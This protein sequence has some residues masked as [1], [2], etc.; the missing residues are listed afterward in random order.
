ML[1]LS[2]S[3]NLRSRSSPKRSTCCALRA[4]GHKSR[5]S[6]SVSEIRTLHDEAQHELATAEV[7]LDR[8]SPALAASA[9]AKHRLLRAEGVLRFAELPEHATLFAAESRARGVNPS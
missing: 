6:A 4:V 5:S 1:L 7:V 3:A 8:L 9:G 2:L